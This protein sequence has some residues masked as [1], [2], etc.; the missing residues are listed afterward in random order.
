MRKLLLSIAVL[1]SVAIEATARQDEFRNKHRT[2]SYSAMTMDRGDYKVKSNYGAAFT[3]TRTYFLHRKP[4]AG[5]M[6][7]GI[8]ATWFDISYNNYTAPIYIRDEADR[9]QIHQAEIGVQAGLSLTFNPV[10]RL[11][12][13]IYGRYAP[14]FSAQY[15]NGISGNYAGYWI[16]GGS[17]SYGVFG[18]GAEYRTGDSNYVNFSEGGKIPTEM[19][20]YRL[21][22]SLK[23]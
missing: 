18:L 11:N 14:T 4:I 16:G 15:Y 20:G 19:S 2:F 12:I 5:F 17:V 23:F 10:D 3:T 22:I 8:D 1:A 9:T 6:K 21:Y 13:Y 7:F